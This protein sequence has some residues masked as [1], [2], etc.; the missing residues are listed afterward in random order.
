VLGLSQTI[1]PIP[2]TRN[3]P[4]KKGKPNS[5]SNLKPSIYFP[6]D[7]QRQ[8]KQRLLSFFDGFLLFSGPIPS[9]NAF[10][11][12]FDSL[13]SSEDEFFI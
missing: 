4:T 10:P 7:S 8:M 1:A 12:L 6:S 9:K 5:S 11:N 13:L 2:Q 3:L